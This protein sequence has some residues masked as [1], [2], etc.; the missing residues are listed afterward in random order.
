[1]ISAKEPFFGA[2]LTT[3]DDD[4]PFDVAAGC[5]RAL[6]WGFVILFE[7]FIGF[8]DRILGLLAMPRGFDEELGCRSRGRD[9]W[10]GFDCGVT[11]RGVLGASLRIS[12]SAFRFGKVLTRGSAGFAAGADGCPV[13]WAR[14]SPIC[15]IVR[16]YPSVV[17]VTGILW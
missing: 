12:S 14:R 16:I 13:I 4:D 6:G 15:E 2:D 3:G 1:M 8:D 9:T 7:P 5:G 11:V 17:T 10:A